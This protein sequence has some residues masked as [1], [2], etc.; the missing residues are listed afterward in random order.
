MKNVGKKSMTL[1]RGKLYG[2]D[3]CL[4]CGVRY[5]KR[6]LGTYGVHQY[7]GKWFSC[8]FS[9]KKIRPAQLLIINVYRG[10][11]C[12]YSRRSKRLRWEFVER[13]YPDELYFRGGQ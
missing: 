6:K 10:V 2:S 8:V 9:D 13:L 3:I 7:R 4:T 11:D 12:G 1:N 5:K